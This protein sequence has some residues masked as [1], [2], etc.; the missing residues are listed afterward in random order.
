M[1]LRRAVMMVAVGLLAAGVTVGAGVSLRRGPVAQTKISSVGSG[2]RFEWVDVFVRGD[3]G[4][5]VGA[6]QVEVR[7]SGGLVQ[8]VG[9]EGAEGGEAPFYDPAALSGGER[10]VVGGVEMAKG[11]IAKLPNESKVRVARLH[12]RVIGN[13]EY[14]GVLRR[15]RMGMG[16]GSVVRWSLFAE[17]RPSVEEPS[18]HQGTL[19]RRRKAGGTFSRRAGRRGDAAALE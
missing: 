7:G 15:W 12:V 5:A 17:R 14:V 13:V 1:S 10:M 4:A 11:Q 6:W 9:V 16:S 2:E 3:A 19:I 18:R 8:F